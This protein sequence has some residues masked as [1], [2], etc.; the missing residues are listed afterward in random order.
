[1]AK[2]ST[3]I[4]RCIPTNPVSG[5]AN[6]LGELKRDGL[7][8]LPGEASLYGRRTGKPLKGI[9]QDYL[10]A[11][12]AI[13]PIISDVRKFAEV[14]THHDKVL[15]QYLRDS[16]KNIRRSYRFPVEST[17]VSSV[18]SPSYFPQG[19]NLPAS[20]FNAGVLHKQVVTTTEAWFSGKFTY[21]LKLEDSMLGK[22]RLHTQLANKLLGVRLTPELLWNLTPWTW[23]VDWESN[24]GDVFHNISQFSH[25]GLVMRYGYVM[26]QKTITTT[27]TLRDYSVKS[28]VS[29]PCPPLSMTITQQRKARKRASPFGFGVT[30]EDL[31]PRQ[32]AIIAA[33]G[34]SQGAGIAK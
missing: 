4:S 6:F 32:I 29:G 31:S 17:T 10:S 2:G 34:I 26:E 24:F 22:L 12:F 21:Y 8:S 30:I 19:G 1:M 20:W 27:Y 9:S 15:K 16:G 14:V 18:V 28:G 25:D 13:R 7:P 33:L 23:A 5:L 3:A 11:E